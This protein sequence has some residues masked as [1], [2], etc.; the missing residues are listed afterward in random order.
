MS[1]I[2][3]VEDDEKISFLL[4]FLLNREGYKVLK[5]EDGK[6]ASELIAAN[7]PPELVLLDLMLPF[8]DGHELLNEIRAKESWTQVPVIMLTAQVQSSEVKRA[9]EEGA[10]E[11][12]VKPFQPEELLAR[13]KRFMK[14]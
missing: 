12:L 7:E 9:L 3:I 5:A 4:G 1:T 13:I 2:M 11:Y 14:K 8:K 6:K 10:N